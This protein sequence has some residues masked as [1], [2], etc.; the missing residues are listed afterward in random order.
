MVNAEGTEG[1][2]LFQKRRQ[3]ERERQEMRL[4]LEDIPAS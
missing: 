4:R 3:K 1:K 2:A